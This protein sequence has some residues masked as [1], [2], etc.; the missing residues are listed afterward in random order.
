[1]FF[2]KF[3]TNVLSPRLNDERGISEDWKART[4]AGA[5]VRV[6][7]ARAERHARAHRGPHVVGLRGTRHVHLHR[8]RHLV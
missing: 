8:H 7:A 2:S 3:L 4:R 5:V 6:G 1:M